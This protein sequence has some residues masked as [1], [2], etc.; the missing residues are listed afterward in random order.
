MQ[1]VWIAR[2]CQLHEQELVEAGPSIR[3]AV[4]VLSSEECEGADVI[5]AAVVKVFAKL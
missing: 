5:K 2:A 4:M 3:L 1:G